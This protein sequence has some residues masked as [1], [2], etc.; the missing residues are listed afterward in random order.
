MAKPTP[1]AK[2]IQELR[3]QGYDAEKVEQRLP[4]PG[5]FVTR[6]LFQC[7]DVIA[8][9]PGAPLR[10]IQVT[11]RDHVNHRMVKAEASRK[12]RIWVSTGNSFE[13]WGYGGKKT[14]KRVVRLAINGDWIES[15]ED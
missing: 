2:A 9:K 12:A 3:A 14:T 15:K 11:T 7:I 4:I 5:R 10:G 8:M 1:T 13:I 6:D